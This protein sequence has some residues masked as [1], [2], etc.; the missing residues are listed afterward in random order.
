M[1]GTVEDEFNAL[2]EALKASEYDKNES[3]LILKE[4]VD[5]VIRNNVPDNQRYGVSMTAGA[6]TKRVR[7]HDW[8]FA[9]GFFGN[10][11]KSHL[12]STDV[13]DVGC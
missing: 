3:I 1:S 7:K 10:W 4:Y 13:N 6:F 8:K 5:T 11:A 12:E 2:V 9:H